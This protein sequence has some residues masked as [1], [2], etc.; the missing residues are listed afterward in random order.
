MELTPPFF[1][2]LQL[3]E[4]IF[5]MP[6]SLAIQ[7]VQWFLVYSQHCAIQPCDGHCYVSAWPAEPGLSPVI[8]L[9]T[10]IGAAVKV[11]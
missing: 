3:Y 10:R 6:Y 2:F 5:H 7:R 11:F 1:F 9:N 8:Q 4:D